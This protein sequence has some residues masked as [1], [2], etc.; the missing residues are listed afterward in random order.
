M[1]FDSKNDLYVLNC[2]NCVHYNHQSRDQGSVSVYPAGKSAPSR[3]I[4]IGIHNPISA[5]LNR[6]DT[7]YV[8]NCTTEGDPH[9]CTANY[10]NAPGGGTVTVYP[11]GADKPKSTIT[12]GIDA[13]RTIAVDS[14]G[15]LYV[16]NLGDSEIAVYDSGATTPSY[17][18]LLGIF[19]GVF[20]SS[21]LFDSSDDLYVA[22]C[23][24]GATGRIC[25]FPPGSGNA[26]A[27][28]QSP[29]NYFPRILA[30][31]SAGNLYT[32]ELGIDVIRSGP[33]HKGH[34]AV[35]LYPPGSGTASKVV[36][37]GNNSAT[38]MAVSR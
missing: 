1:A 15:R 27:Y 20:P 4:T 28:L 26:I 29:E 5:A 31:D 32:L 34:I 21:M 16:A 22:S 38:A 18:I 2:P 19:D 30:F 10:Y 24:F 13:P 9:I 6:D 12:N 36:D 11:S 37:T 14:S 8:A 3:T 23:A 35:A 25:V 7:L 33:N 17:D